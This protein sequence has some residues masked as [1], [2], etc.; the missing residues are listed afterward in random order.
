ML[1]RLPYLQSD[2]VSDCELLRLFHFRT[3]CHDYA[4]GLVTKRHGLAHDN[5]AIAVMPIVV[6]IR[7][8]E[9]GG[10]DSYLDVCWTRR[11]NRAV[12]L[13]RLVG[14]C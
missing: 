4:C 9:A 6:E 5:V 14:R 11:G 8:A 12:F 2:L 1:A 7:A 10:A 3:N 13:R